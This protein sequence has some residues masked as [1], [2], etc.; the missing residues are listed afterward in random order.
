MFE[1]FAKS[2]WMSPVWVLSENFISPLL[3]WMTTSPF[4]TLKRPHG[5]QSPPPLV[6]WHHL[7]LSVAAA[8]DGSPFQRR[9]PLSGQTGSPRTP[10]LYCLTLSRLSSRGEQDFTYLLTR[11]HW[12]GCM[13][14]GCFIMSRQGRRICIGTDLITPCNSIWDVKH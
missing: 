13:M 4:G 7:T 2:V 1:R 5:R 6:N 11:M 3:E 12:S 10:W 14:K 8:T 9:V